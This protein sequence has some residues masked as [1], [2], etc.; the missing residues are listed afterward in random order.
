MMLHE[1]AAATKKK[2]LVLAIDYK[3]SFDERCNNSC[4]TANKKSNAGSRKNDYLKQNQKELVLSS[5]II[6]HFSYCLLI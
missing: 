3:L 4:K 1:N 5:L 2:K 6:S